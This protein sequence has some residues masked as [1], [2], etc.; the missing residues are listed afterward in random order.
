MLL[1]EFTAP[2]PHCCSAVC[3]WTMWSSRL[4]MLSRCFYCWMCGLFIG[5][6]SKLEE[7]MYSNHQAEH[8][9]DNWPLVKLLFFLSCLSPNRTRALRRPSSLMWSARFPLRQTA[10]QWTY[11]H[12]SCVV[13][14]LMWSLTSHAFIGK[15]VDSLD[16]AA[17][18]GSV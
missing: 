5:F 2:Q 8:A 3:S 7:C 11:R 18:F 4:T 13:T 1:F 17:A 6:L 14:W 15:S 9:E 12:M 16:K 10:V